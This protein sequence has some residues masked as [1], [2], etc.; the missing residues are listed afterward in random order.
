M[1][2]QAP[3]AARNREPIRDVLAR[4]LPAHGLVLELA[5][6]SGEHT[7]YFAQC[8]PQLTW[9]PS[10]RDEAALTSI[11]AWRTELAL[12]NVRA[13]LRLDVEE[14]WP[15][16]HADTITCINMLHISPWQA[17]LG[18]FAGAAQLLAPG[19][20][21][22][23]YGP[24]RFDGEFT[25]PSNAEFDRSLRSRN[26][27]WGVRDVRDLRAA[28]AGFTLE[29]VVAMPANNHSLIFRRS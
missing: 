10:D 29:E 7:M 4:V 14:R 21:L 20:V 28:A 25:A 23:T 17:A 13:P 2:L 16:E 22:F 9:Q 12:A 6:G 11:E 5:S 1:K 3:A 18:M 15:I 19:S 26:A 8:F 27:E 24:Y